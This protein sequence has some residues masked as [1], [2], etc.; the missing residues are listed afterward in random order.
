MIG[1]FNTNMGGFQAVGGLVF[2]MVAIG[3]VLAFVLMRMDAKL[4]KGQKAAEEE[5]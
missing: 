4:L 5:A 1:Y 2:G 3:V